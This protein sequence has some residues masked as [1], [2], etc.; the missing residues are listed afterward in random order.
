MN[1]SAYH[2]AKK[3]NPKVKKIKFLEKY[4]LEYKR[5]P[6]YESLSQKE[7]AKLMMKKLEAR[8][9]EIIHKRFSEGKKFLGRKAI[10]Q[11]KPGS[12][13][14]QTKNSTRNSHRP[15]V[16]CVCPQRRAETLKWYFSIYNLYK[17]IS[18]AYR[19]GNSLVSFPPGTHKPYCKTSTLLL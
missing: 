8:R 9:L 4:I 6:G 1:W 14:I 17:Q 13:P 11:T 7:Y 3:L 19:Q 10:L 18:L 5:L 2:K 12:L 15:R 16:L